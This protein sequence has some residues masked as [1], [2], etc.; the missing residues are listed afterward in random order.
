MQLSQNDLLKLIDWVRVAVSLITEDAAIIEE[1][2][3]RLKRLTNSDTATAKETEHA[4][5]GT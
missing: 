1:Y 5:Q 4:A 3:E 2:I